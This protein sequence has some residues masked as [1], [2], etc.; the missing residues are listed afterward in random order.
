MPDSS[1][2]AP[3]SFF[4]TD[5]AAIS[6]S[7]A[8]AFG[9]IDEDQFRLTTK[10]S[11]GAD[12]PAYAICTGIVLVQPLATDSTRVN[13][14]LRPFKQPIQGLNIQYFIYRGLKIL[15]FFSNDGVIAATGSTSDLIN[16]VNAAFIAYYNH[17]NPG[18]P[19]PEFKAKYIGYDPDNQP[20]S[21]LISDLFFKRSVAVAGEDEAMAFELPLIGAGATLGNF[22]QGECGLDIVLSYGDYSLPAPNDEFR[23]DLAYAR[24]AEKIIDISGETDDFKKKQVREQI[25]QFLDAAAY[26]GFHYRDNGSV[27]LKSVTGKI[28]KTEEQ[29]Y[30]DVILNFYTKNCMYLYIQSDRTRSYN[31]YGNYLIDE[32]SNNSMKIGVA[33]DTLTAIP[34]H[35]NGWPL[36]IDKTPQQHEEIRNRLFFQFVTDNNV[37]TMFYARVA[38]IDNAQGNNFCNADYLKLPADEN[39]VPNMFT[40]VLQLSNPSVSMGGDKLYVANFNILIYQGKLYEY[41]AGKETD[42][43]G[44]T[45][46]I[47]QQPDFFDDVFDIINASPLLKGDNDSSNSIVASQKIKLVNHIYD[48]IQYG[49]SAVQTLI[50]KDLI[51]TELENSPQLHC[52]IYAS[53]A[54]MLLS[55]AI[56]VNGTISAIT[57]STTSVPD[58]VVENK[59]YTLPQSVFYSLIPFTDD[60]ENVN[61][62]DLRSTENGIPSMLILGLTSEENDRLKTL[63]IN[64]DLKNVRIVFDD[65][66]ESGDELV[67]IEGILY[68][69]YKVG[70]VGEGKDGQLHLQVNDVP[71]II[72][73]LD[74]RYYFSKAFSEFLT[75][76]NSTTSLVLDLDIS[77]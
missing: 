65:F 19:I 64:N 10:F 44:I 18:G 33:E 23:F 38:Q 5:P 77:L 34:F 7:A 42:D 11:L 15:D 36:L 26:Y 74:R 56:S 37:N 59:N 28:I 48:N 39:G 24:A 9:P 27:S 30:N 61:G 16:S 31:F 67:S 40:K 50:I 47:Y 55:N 13:L 69:K 12:T 1:T 43:Q 45:A 41:I 8:Q 21:M 60:L 3:Q 20:D 58:S 35:S 71:I 63:D 68:K 72:Y 14:V 52:I 53:E 29:I 46:D 51:N 66:F 76:D 49:I 25:C 62:I 6:Q 17:V 57:E 75:N 70:I 22:G 4:F 2:F 73:T 54:I 32:G